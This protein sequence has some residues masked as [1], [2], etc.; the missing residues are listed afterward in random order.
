MIL[1]YSYLLKH[2]G[3]KKYRDKIYRMLKYED[4][5]YSENEG[6]WK[7]LRREEN[8]CY[9]SNVWCHGGSGILL[10]RL[11]LLCLD[12]FK[13]DEIVRK[14]IQRGIRCLSLWEK[15]ERLCICHGLTGIYLIYKACARVLKKSDYYFE[16]EKVRKKILETKKIKVQEAGSTS[17]MTGFGGL[18][19]VLCEADDDLIW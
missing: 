4:S 15:E 8:A 10:S 14:D 6:N 18:A 13:D 1:A 5:L 2:T 9:H 19:V 7:D 16:A 3:D 12:V 11:A 17:L